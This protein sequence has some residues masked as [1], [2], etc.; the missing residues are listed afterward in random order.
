MFLFANTVA[1]WNS[2]CSKRP[3][4][5]T[6]LDAGKR[7]FCRIFWKSKSKDVKKARLARDAARLPKTLPLGAKF[8]SILPLTCTYAIA[9]LY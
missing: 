2:G 5:I 4:C 1:F 9:R 3:L 8:W 6:V 7:V